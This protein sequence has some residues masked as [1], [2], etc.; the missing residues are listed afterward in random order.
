MKNRKRLYSLTLLSLLFFSNTV[1]AAIDKTFGSGSLIIPMDGTIYQN[2]HDEGIYE[3]YGLVYQLLNR[4]A[5]NG[6]PDPIPV[7][8]I[9]DDQKTSIHGVDLLL[10]HTSIDPVAVELKKADQEISITGVG[11]QIAYNG[12]PFVIDQAHAAD[13]KLIWEDNF[14]DVNMHVAKIPFTASVQRELVGIPPKIALMNNQENRNGNAK[15]ILEGYLKIAQITNPNVDANGNNCD[16]TP[17]SGEGCIYDVLTPYEVGGI[18][19]E[20]GV[21]LNGKSLLFDYSCAGCATKPKPNY[22][23]LW[24]P[25]W[26]GYKDYLTTVGTYS[27]FNPAVGTLNTS[28]ED[29]HDVVMAIRDFIDI[30]NSLFAE[31]ASIETFEWSAYGRFLT[32]YDIGHNGGTNNSLNVYNNKDALDW[33]FVQTGDWNFTPEGGHLHNWR[34]HQTGDL[35]V[36]GGPLPMAFNP[37]SINLKST[38]TQANTGYDETVTVLTYDDPSVPSGTT[39]APDIHAY[40]NGQAANKQWHYYLGGHMDGDTTNGYIVYLGGHSYVNC[41][42]TTEGTKLS[43]HEIRFTF[44]QDMSALNDL[45]ITIVYKVDLGNS[46]GKVTYT[47]N[48]I[49][50]NAANIATKTLLNTPGNLK[51]DFSAASFSSDGKSIT[52]T[53][54]MNMNST[55]QFEVKSVTFTWDISGGKLKE[56]FDVTEDTNVEKKE[57]KSYESGQKA[58]LKGLKIA[59]KATE[60]NAGTGGGYISG[61]K[62]TGDGEAGAGIRYVLNTIFQLDA[63]ADREFVRSSPVVYEDF[64][65]QGSFDYPSFAGHFRKFQVNADLGAGKKGLKLNA[66]FGLGGDAADLMTANLSFTDSN[67][68]QVV[69]TNELSGRNIFSSTETGLESGLILSDNAQIKSFKFENASLFQARMGAIDPLSLSETEDVV[70]KRYGMTF[71]QNSASWEKK[72]NVLGG[73]E[74]SSPVIIGPSSLSNDTRPNM[75][76]VG[77]INGMLHAFKAGVKNATSPSNPGELFDAGEEVWAYIPSSQLPR[78]RYFRNPN[79]ISTYPAIDAPL[80]FSEVPDPNHSNQYITVLLA[81]T[82]IGTDS[83]FALD[84]TDPLS[85][86]L[87]PKLL[88]ERSGVDIATSQVIMGS[89]SKVAIGKVVN[90]SG[91]REYRAYITTALQKGKVPCQDSQG[92]PLGNGSLCGGIQIF[93]FDLITGEQK[94]RFERVYSSNLNNIPGSLALIDPDQNGDEDHVVIGDMEGNTWLLP[95]VPD[96]NQNGLEDTVIKADS[97]FDDSLSVSGD[98]VTDINPLYAPS[99]DEAACTLYPAMPNPCW[100]SGHDQPIGISPTVITLGGRTKLV[101]GTGGTDWASNSDTYAVYVLDITGTNVYNLPGVGAQLISKTILDQGEKIFGG[102]TFSQGFLFFGTAF[103]QV[104]GVS[105]TENIAQ[106]NVG[107]IRGMNISDPTDQWKYS[108]Q[109]KFRGSVFVSR[110]ELYATTLDGKIIDL[111]DGTFNEPSSLSWYKLKNWR[112][113]TNLQTNE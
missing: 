103:G 38:F 75:A 55:G 66:G 35:T 45:D 28:K 73:I 110:G 50:I 77:S 47:M 71:S 13:A 32:K 104:E 101:W 83:L 84:V 8:W 20:T 109:G 3:A 54:F 19:T 44:D 74:H 107:N 27:S 72:S 24:V 92:T 88:W 49:D 99:R 78:L 21:P 7:Y 14:I 51:V 43:D 106:S 98:I 108:A 18:Q 81:T 90:L 113:V 2:N 80:T 42:T 111:G 10:T 12:G 59:P 11:M 64:L 105:P 33:P 26:V 57:N 65:Y 52:G 89:G 100:Q 62:G 68:N 58:D 31:C 6:D 30:G 23:V 53:H 5:A 39:P 91:Q 56:I 112:A 36:T 40:Q 70:S 87:Q 25:H 4:K 22:S 94:W 41:T 48:I 69:D 85:L 82:G 61:C 15:K 46:A 9:I 67:G 96:Y 29:V 95:A 34:P 1:S 97:T 60:G 102:I 16:G 79:A 76:Y 93:A 17:V 86:P 63:V 37:S